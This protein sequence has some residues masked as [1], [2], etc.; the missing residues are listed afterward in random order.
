MH[1]RSKEFYR[2]PASFIHFHDPG[3][4]KLSS[5]STDSFTSYLIT[6]NQV[7]FESLQTH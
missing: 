5:L 3:K 6:Y 7:I 4:I 1:F 2:N